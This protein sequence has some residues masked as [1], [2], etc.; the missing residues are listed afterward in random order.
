MPTFRK[1]TAFD[2]RGFYN[3]DRGVHYAQSRYLLY[4]LQQKG[5]LTKFYRDFYARQKT[6]PT[7]YQT[8]RRTL[9]NVDMRRFKQQWEKYVLGLEQGYEVTSRP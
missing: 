2:A 9:G 7:G 6:D 8:L 4:Y 5:L 3:D 1:L